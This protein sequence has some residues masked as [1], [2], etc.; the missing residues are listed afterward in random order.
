M[1][2]QKKKLIILVALVVVGGGV[3]L[4]LY[5]DMIFGKDEPA[6]AGNDAAPAADAGA[7]PPPAAGTQ[8]AT[9]NGQ[10]GA[11][12]DPVTG[13]AKEAETPDRDLE[14]PEDFV[15]KPDELKWK[16]TKQLT[17]E[18]GVPRPGQ[19]GYVFDPF[20][21]K[22]PDVADPNKAEEIN[23]VRD[24]WQINGITLMEEQE[25]YRVWFKNR[26][27][28]YGV[29]DRLTGTRFKI[30]AIKFSK[31][32]IV[33]ELLGDAGSTFNME[34]MPY[35]RYGEEALGRDGGR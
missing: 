5:R 12:I 4:F 22:N 18:G 28:S 3:L 8:P 2:A 31:E 34:F 15:Y 27:K 16:W 25:G 7:P 20:L 10:P 17:P 19:K 33:V 1:D 21:V 6:P 30:A 11:V 23:A 24:A 29:G 9:T 14:L 35:S 26:L 32:K 13:L